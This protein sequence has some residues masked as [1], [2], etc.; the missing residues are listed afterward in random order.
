M[1]LTLILFISITGIVLGLNRF[2]PF[3]ICP[4]CA[5]VSST[6]LLLTAAS[7][8]GYINGEVF[9]PFILLLMG[10]SVVGIAY[11]GE[12]SLDWAGRNTLVWKLAVIAIGMPLASWA[13]AGACIKVLSVEVIVLALLTY[14]FFVKRGG[15]TAEEMKAKTSGA[16]KLEEML[17]D[18]C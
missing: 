13:A 7:L 8:A 16:S 11:Q 4:I 12:K 5:G 2:L 18:C 3:R 6:W 1:W 10:G 9:Q 14:L 17:K 15:K